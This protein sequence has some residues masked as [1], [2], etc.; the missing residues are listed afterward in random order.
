LSTPS[1]LFCLSPI[2]TRSKPATYPIAKAFFAEKP[3]AVNTISNYLSGTLFFGLALYFLG[4]LFFHAK[5]VRGRNRK[6]EM[7]AQ[8]L[9]AKMKEISKYRFWQQTQAR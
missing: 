2:I 1:F 3:P 6:S 7:R 5:M 9:V 8:V 4:T